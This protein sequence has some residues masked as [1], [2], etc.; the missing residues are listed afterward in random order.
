M[1]KFFHISLQYHKQRR[2]AM[3]KTIILVL[4]LTIFF[5]LLGCTPQTEVIERVVTE[6]VKETVVETQVTEKIVTEVVIEQV[7]VTAEPKQKETVTMWLSDSTRWQCVSEKLIPE[8]NLQSPKTLMVT[9]NKANVNE[10][11]RTALA[12]G[13]A[14]DI[15]YTDIDDA[16]VMA[17]AGLLLPLDN[18][19]AETGLSELL[20]PWAVAAGTSPD[21][22]LYQ[23]PAENETL[24]LFY[25]KTVFDEYG[26]T[27]PKT[28]DELLTLSEKVEAEGLIPMAGIGLA[29]T[30]CFRWYIGEYMNA[31]AGPEKVHQGL[32]GEIPWTDPAFV[33]ALELLDDTMQKGWF[34]GSVD[35]FFAA[36]W[37][38]FDTTFSSGEAVMSIEGTWFNGR[39]R[40]FWGEA[41][42]NKNDWDWVPMPTKS[43]QPYYSLSA[44]SSWAVNANTE[45]V[46]SVSEFLGWYLS[47]EIQAKQFAV[48]GTP[49]AP[50]PIDPKLMEG[51]DPRIAN[52][53]FELNNAASKGNFGFT[54]WTFWPPETNAYAREEIQKVWTGAIT[55]EQF[56]DGFNE[57]FSKEFAEGKVPA[58][59]PKPGTR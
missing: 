45:K 18:I 10:T 58:S 48:C 23:I 56:L 37:S 49:P 13:T 33:E 29:C 30:G 47:P 5:S 28:V 12:A 25:N 21:G 39:F 52:I 8:F 40:N 31:V 42:G 53:F 34:M 41:A 44:G 9:T 20:A 54:M 43:G 11:I 3:K 36:D 2:L 6:V 24:V 50:V 4:T 38:T 32:K 14:P 26:W 57:V 55:V 51:V 15:I 1:W 46:A 19:A 17:E 59:I 35:R 7:Q 22:A 27:P 16:A